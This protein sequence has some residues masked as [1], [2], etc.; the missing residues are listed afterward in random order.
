MEFKESLL[1]LKMIFTEFKLSSNRFQ[2]PI[3]WII[4]S[5]NL[6]IVHISDENYQKFH[7]FIHNTISKLR[8]EF[9]KI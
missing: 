5:I 6:Y 3:L 7:K 2:Q 1:L 4:G 9:R 8:S